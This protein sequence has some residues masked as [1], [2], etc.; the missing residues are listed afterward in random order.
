MMSLFT[1]QP[2]Q[3]FR[4]CESEAEGE[5]PVFST[6]RWDGRSSEALIKSAIPCHDAQMVGPYQVSSPLRLTA[7]TTKSEDYTTAP[8]GAILESPLSRM[9]Q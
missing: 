5:V 8:Q 4:K 7:L 6:K 1:R 9:K 3:P 2:Y